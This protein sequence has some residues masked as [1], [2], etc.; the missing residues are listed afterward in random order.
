M[1]ETTI[2]GPAYS[3]YSRTVRLVLEE[4]GAP[5]KMVEVDILKGDGQSPAHLARHPYGKV[6]TVELDGFSLYETGAIERYLDDAVPGPKLIP[7]DPKQRARMNQIMGLV[8]SYGYVPIVHGVAVNRLV[9]P[10]LGQ[11][12]DEAEIAKALPEAE[13]VLAEIENL[14]GQ[15]P[16]LAGPQLSLADL[17]LAPALAYF[18]MT[19]E[20]EAMLKKFPRLSEW[21]SKMKDRPSM[22]K[23]APKL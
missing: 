7:T 20:G 13:K 9:K 18:S 5:Y 12:P 10:I 11:K 17:H 4:K 8:D 22:A 1:G 2:Y 23:T 3:T 16:F 19:P 6:P 15:N 14:M 21:W